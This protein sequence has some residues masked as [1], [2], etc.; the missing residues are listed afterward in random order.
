MNLVENEI[1]L[2]KQALAQHP[3]NHSAAARELGITPQALYRKI[4]KFGLEIT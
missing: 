3:S 2:I 1:S 4:E